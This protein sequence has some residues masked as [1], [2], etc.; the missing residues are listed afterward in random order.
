MPRAIPSHVGRL[1]MIARW[2]PVHLGHAAVLE[3]LLERADEVIVG[4]GSSN[5]YNARNPFT[6]GE[7]ATMIH[8][9]L[10][11]H[12]GYRVVEVPD[13]DDGPRWR[14]MVKDMLGPL[15]LFVTANG[16]VRSLLLEDYPILHPVHLVHPERRVPLDGSMVRA[17]MAR[18][19]GWRAMVPEAIAQYLDAHG[20]VER[21]RA[22]FGEAL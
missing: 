19:D 13:L 6:S 9:A 20:L 15:D 2:K 3:S 16:Y 18:G 1:A 5:R 7:S 21:L 11:G 22:E 4:I 17:A 12:A 10:R 8:L 14:L